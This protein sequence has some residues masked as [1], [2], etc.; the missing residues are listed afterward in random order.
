LRSNSGAEQAVSH[1]RTHA[2]LF[3]DI[4]EVLKQEGR[5]RSRSG[6][7]RKPQRPPRHLA[8]PNLPDEGRDQEDHDLKQAWSNSLKDP[9]L[10]KPNTHTHTHTKQGWNGSSSR[11]PRVQTPVTAR[12]RNI[13]I[14]ILLIFF[15]NILMN[16]FQ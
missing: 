14:C 4:G 5:V 11:A 2:H 15:K 1:T 16:V 12:K 6:I 13:W 8:E 9:S 7:G 10:K 3:E